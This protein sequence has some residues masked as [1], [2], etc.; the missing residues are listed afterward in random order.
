MVLVLQIVKDQ[1]VLRKNRKVSKLLR[2]LTSTPCA[3]P[4]LSLLHSS[5]KHLDTTQTYNTV[6]EL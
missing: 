3:V 4:V 6:P 1:Q 5:F 2:P